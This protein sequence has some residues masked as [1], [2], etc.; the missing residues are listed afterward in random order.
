MTLRLI[1]IRHAKSSW[2]DPFG[3]DHKRARRSSC[4]AV[5]TMR[6]PIQSLNWSAKRQPHAW[7]SSV[8]IQE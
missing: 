2:D 7:Q 4:Q 6:H 1:L 5:F 3:D 8:I